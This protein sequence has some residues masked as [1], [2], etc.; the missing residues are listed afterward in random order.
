MLARQ[1]VDVT[2]GHMNVIWQNDAVAQSIQALRVAGSPAV[3][4]NITGPDLLSVREVATRFGELF[5]VP[6]EIVG[7]E[8][9]TAWLNNAARSHRL[10]GAPA[11]SVEQMMQWI[12]AWLQQGGT[13]WG[14]PTG[15]ERRDGRF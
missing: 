15:F 7:R 1:P 13:T 4:L 8:A 5:G 12:A 2:T 9:D 6:V 11:T 3:P 14:K 10:F